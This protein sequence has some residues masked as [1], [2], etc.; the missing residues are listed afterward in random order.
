LLADPLFRQLD[1]RARLGRLAYKLNYAPLIGLA[2][3]LAP[4]VL[5]FTPWRDRNFV[6]IDPPRLVL[7][8]EARA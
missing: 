4:W 3:W 2:W 7:D 1:L 5:R 6:P 8:H